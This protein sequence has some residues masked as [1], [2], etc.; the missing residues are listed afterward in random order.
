MSWR[1]LPLKL[2]PPP[3]V[4]SHLNDRHGNVFNRREFSLRWKLKA[5]SRIQCRSS[6]PSNFCS[7][8]GFVYKLSGPLPSKQGPRSISCALQARQALGQAM[9]EPVAP[10]RSRSADNQELWKST[11][12]RMLHMKA[13]PASSRFPLAAA[14]S[15]SR[16]C[17]ARAPLQLP[18]S[19]LRSASALQQARCPR[20]RHLQRREWH[21]PSVPPAAYGCEASPRPSPLT[22]QVAPCHKRYAHDWST[23]P[24]SHPRDAARRRDPRVH[25]HTG[26]ACPAMKQVGPRRGGWL[27]NAACRGAGHRAAQPSGPAC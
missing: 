12:W 1:R 10:R 15:P 2:L 11:E 16:T 18:S 17:L 19:S 24:Y 14:A 25:P 23:C 27:G 20:G 5:A 7:T 13:S 22:L 8:P 9:S 21:R 6:I 4:P 3:P 26:I